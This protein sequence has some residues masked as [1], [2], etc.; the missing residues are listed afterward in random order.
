M[1]DAGPFNQRGAMGSKPNVEK[2]RL[3]KRHLL[4]VQGS[5]LSAA[6]YC[7]LHGLPYKSMVYWKRVLPGYE[8]Q[9]GPGPIPG[10]DF[11][12]I[13]ALV[14]REPPQALA[15]GPIAVSLRVEVGGRFRIEVAGDF[16][17]CVFAKLVHTLEKLR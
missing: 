17:S 6:A 4:A 3:W 8:L 11:E 15:T 12:E 9:A 16:S 10:S 13:T 14:L 2:R 1:C 5:G 7:R